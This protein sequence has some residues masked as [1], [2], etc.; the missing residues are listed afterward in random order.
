L[1]VDNNT[2]SQAFSEETHTKLTQL[3]S[4]LSVM[5]MTS[6]V[7]EAT[8]ETQLNVLGLAHDLSLDV[9]RCVE[10]SFKGTNTAPD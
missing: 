4:L 2:R 9:K 1:I 5:R 8:E 6:F 10:S 7:L 3:C